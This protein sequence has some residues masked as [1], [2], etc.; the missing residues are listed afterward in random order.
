MKTII[1][2]EDDPSQLTALQTSLTAQFRVLTA[3]DCKA[4]WAIIIKEHPDLLLLDIMLPG[5]MNGFDLL[6][7]IKKDAQVRDM[8]VVVLT[9][10]DTEED[11]TRKIGVADYLIKSNT[12]IAT[13]A[14]KISAIL[15]TS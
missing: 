3:M 13:I 9:N 15:G 10:L 4:G 5:G 14:A 1:I 7:Q 2:I 12:S 6:E 11:A 8:P